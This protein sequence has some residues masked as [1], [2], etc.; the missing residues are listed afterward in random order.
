VRRQVRFI[1]Q[2]LAA[3]D[4]DSDMAKTTPG[5]KLSPKL[6][7][8]KEWI[9]DPGPEFLGL[10]RAALAKVNQLKVAFTK[11]VNEILKQGQQ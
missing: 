9:F 1:A 11:N 4:G 8:K 10:N 5:P 7:F 6:V 3:L 2:Y